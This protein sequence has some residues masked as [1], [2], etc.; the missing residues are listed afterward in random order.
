MMHLHVN[1]KSDY[2][3]DDETVWTQ[4][5]SGFNL[6]DTDRIL[7]IIFRKLLLYIKS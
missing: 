1:Q 4:L 5:R 2:D 7:E 6:F 3:D